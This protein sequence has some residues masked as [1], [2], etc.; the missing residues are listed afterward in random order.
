[1][2]PDATDRLTT[3]FTCL[4]SRNT[5]S[6]RLMGE[7][8]TLTCLG[9]LCLATRS[10]GFSTTITALAKLQRERTKDLLGMS[11]ASPGLARNSATI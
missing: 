6:F 11:A 7:T 1:M 2:P 9:D 10:E 5:Q 3:T 4:D 8:T